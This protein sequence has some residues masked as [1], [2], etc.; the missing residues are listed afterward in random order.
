M[1]ITESRSFQ[2]IT[3]F[4]AGNVNG[5]SAP[6]LQNEIFRASKIN[7]FIT[8]DFQEVET[9]DNLGAVALHTG[10]RVCASKR[11]R[12]TVVNANAAVKNEMQNEGLGRVITG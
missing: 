4:V 6:Q 9:F 3:L 11:G 10:V 7:A 8:L 5:T 1:K 2:G 12:L